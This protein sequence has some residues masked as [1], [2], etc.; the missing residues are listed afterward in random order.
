M[1]N[2]FSIVS[3]PIFQRWRHP[4]RLRPDNIWQHFE[5]LYRHHDR[6]CLERGPSAGGIQAPSGR[7]TRWAAHPGRGRGWDGDR[8]RPE[9]L[10]EQGRSMTNSHVWIW[11]GCVISIRDIY[12]HIKCTRYKCRWDHSPWVQFGGNS[13][14]DSN[15]LIC[16]G[17]AVHD[18]STQS[19]TQFS[20]IHCPILFQMTSRYIEVEWLWHYMEKCRNAELIK[21]KALLVR[22]RFLTATVAVFA[23]WLMSTA[24]VVVVQ[25]FA[26]FLVSFREWHWQR[27][28][29]DLLHTKFESYLIP[30]A[31][32]GRIRIL[33]TVKFCSLPPHLKVNLAV[34][35]VSLRTCPKLPETPHSV[36]NTTQY[37]LYRL[38]R[39]GKE[40]NARCSN[41]SEAKI[42]RCFDSQCRS[43]GMSSRR[44]IPGSDLETFCTRPGRQFCTDRGR[45]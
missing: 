8:K 3:T 34:I 32:Q 45:W 9:A 20:M 7:L 1:F 30:G 40:V 24:S 13:C 22:G 33:Q 19:F 39:R 23:G 37:R 10:K 26:R 21:P 36:P 5:V 25:W 12:W 14:G 38:Y 11:P 42:P 18:M 15:C 6:T 43:F 4:L 29:S 44:G 35:D 16:F 2:I 17:Q 41:K 27:A 31:L 28:P